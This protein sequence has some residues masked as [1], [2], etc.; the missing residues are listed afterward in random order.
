MIAVLDYTELK[1]KGGLEPWP[2]MEELPFVKVL[3]GKP[4]HSGRFD[5]G[6]FGT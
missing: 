1:D 6:G 5:L 4:V 3:D 2:T